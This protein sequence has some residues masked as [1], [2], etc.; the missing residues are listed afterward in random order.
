MEYL[1]LDGFVCRLKGNYAFVTF[2][3][4]IS[5][6]TIDIDPNLS[7]KS[8][9]V[10]LLIFPFKHELQS[11]SLFSQL[12]LQMVPHNQRPNSYSHILRYQFEDFITK[13]ANFLL[14]QPI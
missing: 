14:S 12:Q 1:Y 11:S 9:I 10:T 13:I 8:Q 3:L 7:H 2:H 4:L 5:H 6:N